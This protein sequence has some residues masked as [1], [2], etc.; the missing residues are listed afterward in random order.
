MYLWLW[1][2]ATESYD[3]LEQYP[4]FSGD[5]FDDGFHYRLTDEG[6]TLLY[7]WFA[8]S[9]SV[10]NIISGVFADWLEENRSDLLTG[11]TGPSDPAERLD[12]LISYLR[13][14]LVTT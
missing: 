11:A 9:P 13:S 6:T 8:V 10:D 2:E 4:H 14:R 3:E 7:Q 1:T 12:R 5:S